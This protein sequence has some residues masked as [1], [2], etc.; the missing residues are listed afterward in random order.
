MTI[1]TTIFTHRPRVS[2]ARFLFCWWRH[3]R[4]LMTSQS[5]DNCDAVTWIVISNSLDIGFIHGRSCKNLTCS[6]IYDHLIHWGLV[7][8]YGVNKHGHRYFQE[9]LVACTVPSHNLNQC[10]LMIHWT[11]KQILNKIQTFTLTHCGLL[12]IVCSTSLMA[13]IIR[14]VGRLSKC[15]YQ[16]L[17][18]AVFSTDV[19]GLSIDRCGVA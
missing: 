18:S 11:L 10:W 5:P 12:V 16:G 6:E 13:L 4:L 14:S 9:W 7:M 1:K 19:I 17:Q 8:P 3:N 2:L 15:F